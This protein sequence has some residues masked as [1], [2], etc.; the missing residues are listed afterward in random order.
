MRGGKRVFHDVQAKQP[1]AQLDAKRVA[2]A[3]RT[4]RAIPSSAEE[5]A[6]LRER[7]A[8]REPLHADRQSPV[9]DIEL[10]WPDEWNGHNEHYK[11]RAQNPPIAPCERLLA[12]LVC[13]H[14]RSVAIP[15]SL[16]EGENQLWRPYGDSNPGRRRERAVS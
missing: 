9:A 15:A 14:F 1:L 12:R 6:T 11:Q 10:D 3:E 5:R 7:A 13:C 16:T 4:C 8:W 2:V